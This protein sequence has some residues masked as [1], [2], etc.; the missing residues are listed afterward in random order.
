MTPLLL[1]SQSA[2]R[3]AMLTAA[4]VPFDATAA[5]VDEDAAKASLAGRSPQ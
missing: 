4:G 3:R 1:A 2:S 5:G